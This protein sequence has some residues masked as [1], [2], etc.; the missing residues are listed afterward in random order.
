MKHLKAALLC[1]AIAFLILISGCSGNT[2][3]IDPTQATL[4]VRVLQSGKSDCI[5]VKAKD[6]TVLIDC[7]DEDDFPVIDKTLKS[8]GIERI[9]LMVLT[10]FDNDHIGS[11]LEVLKEYKVDRVV[12]P[13]YV[14][15]SKL[16]R[17]ILEHLDQNRQIES[18]RLKR[19]TLEIEIA[20]GIRM[21]IC[22]AIKDMGVE[23]NA[24]SLISVITLDDGG[25]LLFTGDATRERLGEF[26][27][28]RPGERYVF[29][30]LAH[31]GGYNSSV[32]QLLSQNDLRYAAVTVGSLEDADN[33]TL[34]LLKKT[35]IKTFF[36]CEGEI[37]L[38]YKDGQ[39]EYS[40]AS[41]K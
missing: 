38:L 8:E 33:K 13:D 14:R 6:Y 29:A 27:E 41:G 31:H 36:T 10:H 21:E 39:Y 20:D 34:V 9:D 18:R 26:L 7:A 40:Q 16:T 30:K 24:N 22:A 5:L 1:F 35:S 11:A 23:D 25:K 2:E 12:M 17:G 28:D 3:G 4:S 15:H 19:E 37:R 32:K